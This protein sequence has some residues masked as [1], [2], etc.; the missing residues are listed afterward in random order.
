MAVRLL[1]S[2]S[3]SA[4]ENEFHHQQARALFRSFLQKRDDFYQIVRCAFRGSEELASFV[5]QL[6]G[7]GL[8]AG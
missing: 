3:V 2:Y 1:V 6:P 8:T 5:L 7:D 4:A